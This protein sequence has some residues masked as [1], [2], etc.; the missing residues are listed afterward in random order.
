MRENTKAYASVPYVK[1]VSEPVRWILNCENIKTAFKPLK[2]LGNVF[3]KPKN[4]PAKEYST[5]IAYKVS[6][7]TC[8]LHILEIVKEIGSLGG[9]NTTFMSNTP[10]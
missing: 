9:L 1:G 3:K 5:E 7:R 8:H 10:N 2:T 6:C 4:W